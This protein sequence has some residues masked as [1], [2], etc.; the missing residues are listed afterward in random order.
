[1]PPT[2]GVSRI[3]ITNAASA[4]YSTCGWSRSASIVPAYFVP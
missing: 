4:P 3:T 2:A 1:M